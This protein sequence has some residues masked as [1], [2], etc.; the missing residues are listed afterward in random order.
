[1]AILARDRVPVLVRS[2]LPG[3][4]KDFQARY[5]EGAVDGILVTSLYLPNGNPQPGPVL[6]IDFRLPLVMIR[7]TLGRRVKLKLFPHQ[8]LHQ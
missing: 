5:I 4:P 6:T 2:S 3:D 8:E 1:M 7:P